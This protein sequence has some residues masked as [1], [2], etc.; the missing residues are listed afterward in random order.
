[1]KDVSVLHYV[2]TFLDSECK[3][4]SLS[5]VCLSQVWHR[6]LKE[7]LWGNPCRIFPSV[8]DIFY[9]DLRST[10]AFLR[11]LSVFVC[12]AF[13]RFRIPGVHGTNPD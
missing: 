3:T 5:F 7:V 11:S 6:A 9:G 13:E 4:H 12:R 2:V 1:M 8:F 10:F